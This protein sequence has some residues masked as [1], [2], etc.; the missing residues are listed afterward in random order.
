MNDISSKLRKNLKNGT[1]IKNGTK[2]LQNRLQR[3]FRYGNLFYRLDEER[4]LMKKYQKGIPGINP[5]LYPAG[6][7]YLDKRISLNEN[8]IVYSLGILTD[9]AFDSYVANNFACEVY[10]YAPTP[11]TIEFM[12]QYENY[13]LFEFRAIGVWIEE[14]SLKFH[15]PKYGGSASIL[16]KASEHAFEAK[17]VTMDQLMKENGHSEIQIFKADIEG[18]ALPVLE[19]MIQN[20]IFPDQIVVELER[21]QS[22]EYPIENYFSRVSAIRTQLKNEGYEEFILPRQQAKYFSLEMLFSKKNRMSK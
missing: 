18:A 11:I 1:L 3:F 14:T 20:K 2:A 9:V 13:P 6:N 4:V 22:D 17:C 19:Q 16:Q 15:N 7:Y 5:N 8:A 12:K 10:M 21:I